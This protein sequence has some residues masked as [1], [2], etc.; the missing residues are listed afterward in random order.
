MDYI[1][2]GCSSLKELNLSNFN[3][4]NLISIKEMFFDCTSLKR[5]NLHYF[6]TKNIPDTFNIFGNYVSLKK[7]EAEN[8]KKLMNEFNR[9]YYENSYCIIL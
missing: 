1:F 4:N 2:N 3:T 5:L 7:V 9:I 6:N 8:S